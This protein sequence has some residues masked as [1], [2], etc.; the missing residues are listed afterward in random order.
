[1]ETSFQGEGN[2]F[3][4]R[5]MTTIFSRLF[6]F[7]C[8][9]F[10]LALLGGVGLFLP[11][12]EAVASFVT[13]HWANGMFFEADG[14]VAGGW[15]DVD[16]RGIGDRNL[17]WSAVAANVL[18]WWQA[19][20]CPDAAADFPADEES[21][22]DAFCSRWQNSPGRSLYGFIWYFFGESDYPGYSDYCADYF[23]DPYTGGFWTR[24]PVLLGEAPAR[25]SSGH[26]GIAILSKLWAVVYERGGMLTLGVF[27]R[28]EEGDFAYAHELTF[29]GF[30]E[31]AAT[32]LVI[33]VYVT[34]S[35]D[36]VD[37]L[38]RLPVVYD[39]D[40]GYYNIA[41]TGS[42]MEGGVIVSYTY[43]RPLN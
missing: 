1:M 19:R 37:G 6:I 40:S 32:G 23:L 26:K 31:D 14:N 28:T 7:S 13:Q 39:E 41:G 20:Y 43:I 17:C 16:K 4:E 42:R 15:H 29:W 25:V 8:G 10:F 3:F 34:D 12:E 38:V 36:G 30:D 21:I 22:Y 9:R 11:G 27:C 33:A 2:V 5:R 24:F 35:D 18:A